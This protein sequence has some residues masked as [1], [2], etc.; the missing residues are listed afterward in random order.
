MVWIEIRINLFYNKFNNLSLFDAT[1]N[2]SVFFFLMQLAILINYYS[3]KIVF[4]R[5]RFNYGERWMV[6]GGGS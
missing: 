4:L 6:P 1:F 2:N 5:F 3:C